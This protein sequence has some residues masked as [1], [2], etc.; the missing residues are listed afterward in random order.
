MHGG[1]SYIPKTRHLGSRG[2]QFFCRQ[3]II[4]CW[5]T[6]RVPKVGRPGIGC[7]GL[8]RE[9]IASREYFTMFGKLCGDGPIGQR[10]ASSVG[11]LGGPW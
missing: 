7:T 9:A 1:T 2:G 5:V 3:S 10:S 11:S 6:Y 8:R 4:V